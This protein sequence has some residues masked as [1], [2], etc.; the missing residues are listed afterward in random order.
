MPALEFIDRNTETAEEFSPLSN[1]EMDQLR[2]SFEPLRAPMEKR[3]V[4][5]L[6]G[7]TQSPGIFWV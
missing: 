7:P 6:D 3:L 1:D 5:H 4:G 2:R